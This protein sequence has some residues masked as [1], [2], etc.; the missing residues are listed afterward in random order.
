MADLRDRNKLEKDLAR[1]LAKLSGAQLGALTRELGD[2]PSLSNV[3]DTFWAR[4]DL[5]LTSL[6]DPFL[7]QIYLQQVGDLIEGVSVGLDWALVNQDAA[8]WS[9]T[10]A[11]NLV[12]ELRDHTRVAV[13]ATLQG[14]QKTLQE[15]ISAGIE[16]SM[17]LSDIRAALAPTFG[18]M[19]AEMI[20]TTEIT[21]AT[22]MGEAGAVER[23]K[24]HGI[25]MVP[26]WQT[27]EDEKVCPVCLGLDG[28]QGQWNGSKWMFEHKE[29]HKLYE[30]GPAHPRCRCPKGWKVKKGGE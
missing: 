8:G 6:L 23:L 7:Q 18:P 11:F 20:A 10:Y 26:E 4:Y 2:P 24:E 25:E 17:P 1:Q 16:Q 14:L 21:R 28:V 3:S 27:R 5:Q 22:D 19:R 29:T 30:L 15:A 9:S 13:D 12:K